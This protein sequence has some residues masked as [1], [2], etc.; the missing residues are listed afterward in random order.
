MND[1]RNLSY[2]AD[3][4]TLIDILTKEKYKKMTVEEL[5]YV[6]NMK[7]T[8]PCYQNLIG[9]GSTEKAENLYKKFHA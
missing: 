7:C 9:D 2:I 6:I 1:Q 8:Y 5:D 4:V 3:T